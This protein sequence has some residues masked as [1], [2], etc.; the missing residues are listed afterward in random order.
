MATPEIVLT[1]T[2]I[3][4]LGDAV[5]G[6]T[7]RDDGVA[8]YVFDKR[9]K[10]L[11]AVKRSTIQ[12]LVQRGL[13]RRIGTAGVHEPTEQAARV[14]RANTRRGKAVGKALGRTRR[15]RVAGKEQGASVEAACAVGGAGGADLGLFNCVVRELDARYPGRSVSATGTNRLF[16]LLHE[17]EQVYAGLPVCGDA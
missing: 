11:R 16:R 6:L 8:G 17:I 1:Q 4:L 3:E 9:G 15:R 5:R 14:L 10:A 12:S 13:L 7:I 2:Q